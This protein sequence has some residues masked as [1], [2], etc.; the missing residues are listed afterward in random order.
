MKILQLRRALRRR[1]GRQ[2][3]RGMGRRFE[4]FIHK[5]NPQIGGLVG[6]EAAA[7]GEFGNGPL[8]GRSNPVIGV[9]AIQRR[10]KDFHACSG[11]FNVRKFQVLEDAGRLEKGCKSLNEPQARLA[12]ATNQRELLE[13]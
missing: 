11:E 6:E 3:S 8:R 5:I 9:Y 4:R 13:G 10:E 1:L 2:A 12:A 7:K